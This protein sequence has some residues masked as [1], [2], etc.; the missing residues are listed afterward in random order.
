MKDIKNNNKIKDYYKRINELKTAG[1]KQKETSVRKAFLE[2]VDKYARENQLTVVDELNQIGTRNTP[3]AGLQSEMGLNYGYIENK[4]IYDNIE[5]EIEKKIRKG[6][7]IENIIFENTQYVILYQNKQQIN[8]IYIGE[9]IDKRATDQEFESLIKTFINYEPP[10]VTNFKIALEKFKEKVPEISKVLHK[11]IKE[12]ESSSSKFREK[13]EVFLKDCKEAV[14]KQFDIEDINNMIVQHILTRDIFDSIF[15]DQQFHKYNAIA[16]SIE[17]ITCTF[18]TKE[19]EMELTK[20]IR[21]YYSAIIDYAK[22]IHDHR[23][24][25]SFLKTIYQEFYKAYHP[26]KADRQGIEYTPIEVVSFMINMTNLLLYKHF[27]QRLE[28]DGVEILDPCTG[29]GIFISEL[30]YQIAYASN[31]DRKFEKEIFCNEIDIL[32][33][34]IANLNIEY[35]R[36]QIKKNYKEFRN[37][38]LVD[39]LNN[40]TSL[41]YGKSTI[42]R[43]DLFS[44]ANRKAFNENNEK[45][46]KH[47]ETKLKVIIGNPPY[48]SNQ[49]NENDNNK[50]FSY[51][52]IDN[53]IRETYIKN[54]KAQ[55]TKQFDLYKRFIRWASDRIDEKKGGII[56]FITNNAYLDAKQDDGFRAC[57]REEFDYAYFVNLKGNANTSGERRRKER[58]NVFDDRIKVGVGIM[59]LLKNG[60]NITEEGKRRCEIK[61]IEVEDYWK[62][63]E[64]LDFLNK[65]T[66]QILNNINL[67]TY[68]QLIANFTKITPNQKNQWLWQIENNWQDLIPVISKDVKG[69]KNT[70]AIFKLYSLG[71]ATNRDKW[72]YDINKNNLEKKIKK[73]IEIYDAELQQNKET[74]EK[75][76][77]LK[78]STA[79]NKDEGGGLTTYFLAHR[80]WEYSL[81]L[82]IKWTDLIKNDLLKNKKIKFNKSNIRDSI[83]RPFCKKYIY[84]PNCTF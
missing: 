3:D 57:V 30:L 72:V 5:I 56:A 47:N 80:K 40:I 32:P 67:R 68:N 61:Y 35:I 2:L 16:K 52:H 51:S 71:V 74:I 62:K 27:D 54:S 59:F 41:Q 77:K 34:Y 70:N 81:D 25:Q 76:N 65:M 53:R 26:S 4:D 42:T 43:Y 18:F 15:D 21:S 13:L 44:E 8:S 78:K 83:Y 82:R 22:S 46:K 6:Y 9:D 50:N 60:D 29:T 66:V 79:E 33:Y 19:K 31:F 1:G 36:A 24:K 14:N 73:F 20:S 37:I 55:K 64:K 28:D 38:V 39:T 7:S 49:Q 84:F 75:L 63:E 69:G 58:G 10:F 23:Q 11:L 12:Q 45:I 48:N 17:D